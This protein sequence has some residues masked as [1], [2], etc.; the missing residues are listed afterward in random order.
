MQICFNGTRLRL[1]FSFILIISFALLSGYE[2]SLFLILFSVMHE[3]GHLTVLL[4]FGADITEISLSFFGF[5]IKYD[6]R[7]SLWQEAFMLSAGAV[8]NL[9]LFLLIRDDINLLLIM[10]NVLPVYPLDGGRLVLLFLPEAGKYISSF[11]LILLLFASVWL[12]F[13]FRIISVLL[14]TVY[15]LF[16]NLRLI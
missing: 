9:L 14:I 13:K 1:D 3:L 5:G 7:L 11:L 4:L 16:F 12:L 10:L 6:A 15:L 8:V 2:K